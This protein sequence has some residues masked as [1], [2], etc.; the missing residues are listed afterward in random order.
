MSAQLDYDPN[1]A[2]NIKFLK[3][4]P[5]FSNLNTAA[6]KQVAK[7][8]SREIYESD[9]VVFEQG[10][11][12][13]F[14]YI[15]ENGTVVA[16][17]SERPIQ[18]IKSGEIF[19][20]IGMV[21]GV[22]RTASIVAKTR[23]TIL[24]VDINDLENPEKVDVNTLVKLYKAFAKK[25][26]SYEHDDD[27]FY[28]DMDVLLFQDGG[29]APGYNSV[30]GYVVRFLE[31]MGRRVF[32]S[33]EG[34]KSI[35]NG[36][37][38]DFNYLINDYHLYSKLE[39]VSG[40]QFAPVLREARGASF[41]SERYKDFIKEE[42]QKKAAQ[43]IIERKVKILVGIGGD[44]T[45]KGL[46][47]LSRFLPASIQ[48]FFIPV[49]IDSDI[50]GT[51]T[52]GEHTGVMV[53][54]E[55]IRSYMADARSH[56][57]LYIIEMMG[58]D[59]GFHAMKS[60]L[61]AGGDMAILPNTKYDI[62]KIAHAL[63]KKQNSVIVVAEGYKRDERKESGFVGNAAD[64]F[65]HELEQSGVQ[66]KMRAISEGFSR[67]IRGAAPNYNDVT[68]SQQMARLLAEAVEQNKTEVMPAVLGGKEYYIPFNE[69]STDNTV[70]Q[71][72]ADL[73]NRLT[74]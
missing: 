11:V 53:G 36:K 40:V 1:Q 25:A 37:T 29:C 51:E 44:G 43:H 50:F 47:A 18:H 12:S 65:K 13:D 28:Q 59:G 74:K 9:E 8:F 45:L 66:L 55:K 56:H 57:R 42:N 38:S 4:V 64:Y 67:D 32:I 49:T 52:I 31:H 61:G 2:S 60:C 72:M 5:E 41:R 46:K 16:Q 26:T 63:S 39:H 23:S 17:L 62:K 19:G 20:E 54:S 10:T 35:V 24:K 69:I 15:V 68:L 30:T 70:P 58:R 27:A 21:G 6:I 71:R 14:V 73:A 3:T 33:K 34:F 22:K 7:L 48:T